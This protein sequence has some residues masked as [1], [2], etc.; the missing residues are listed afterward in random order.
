MKIWKRLVEGWS[1]F[2]TATVVQAATLAVALALGATMIGV[3]AGV[4]VSVK[5]LAASNLEC[6]WSEIN[7]CGD[8]CISHESW[9]DDEAICWFTKYVVPDPIPEPD[10]PDFSDLP[11]F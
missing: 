11:R 4:G 3:G 10:A 6:E 7:S 5:P 8:F 2:R 9:A 1:K